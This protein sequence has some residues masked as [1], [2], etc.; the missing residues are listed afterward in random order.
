MTDTDGGPALFRLV[1][2]W[3][4]RWSTPPTPDDRRVRHIEVLSAAAAA[5]REPTIADVAHQLGIDRSG[6]SRLVRDA[7]DAGLLERLTADPDRRRAAIRPTPAG[8][9]LL[10]TALDWQRAAFA[11][12]TASWEPRDR[13]RF[14]GYLRR[15]A[16]EQ[17]A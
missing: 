16:D 8:T 1:R 12:L 14:G 17:G 13:E 6:A 10:E 5:G 7:A 4:R 2:F 9:Q 11:E 3:S 15:L